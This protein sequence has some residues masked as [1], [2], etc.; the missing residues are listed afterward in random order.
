MTLRADASARTLKPMIVAF[1]V[2]A[3]C[4]SDSVMPPTPDPITLMRICS[5]DRPVSASRNACTE[6]CTSALMI[7][8]RLS[9]ASAAPICAMMSSMRLPA[10]P[11]RRDLATLGIALLRDVLGQALVLDHD[12]IVA[13][14][15]HAG[16][17]EHLH[18]NRRTG[19]LH[20]LAGL[21]EQRAHAAVLHAADQVIALA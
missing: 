17:A 1:D 16:Q 2:A 14:I 11:T 13:R 15:R 12:E 19:A 3:S 9:W 18:R 6:P 7:S 4:A 8:G 21:V 5:L 10:W 20:L